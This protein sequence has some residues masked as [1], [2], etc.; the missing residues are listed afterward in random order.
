LVGDTD[1]ELHDFAQ[2]IGMQRSWFHTGGKLSHYDLTPERYRLALAAGA[3]TM[4]W[5]AF[6]V[7]FLRRKPPEVEKGE[8]A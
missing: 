1:D 3:E 2:R 6:A 4:T 8:I 7:R 5:R